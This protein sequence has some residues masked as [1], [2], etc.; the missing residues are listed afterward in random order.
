MKNPEV[1]YYFIYKKLGDYF[2]LLLIQNKIFERINKV[3]F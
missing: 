3:H 1:K 2:K